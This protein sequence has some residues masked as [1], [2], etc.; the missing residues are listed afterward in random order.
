MNALSPF[1]RSA[2][3]IAAAAVLGMGAL[4]WPYTVDDAFVLAR[5]A[6]RLG[7]GH[8]WT[9]VDGPATDGV[10][11]PLGVVPGALAALGGLDAVLAAKVAGLLGAALAAGLAVRRARKRAIGPLAAYAACGF[12]AASSTLGVWGSA[13]LET[14]LA[15][16][17]ATGLGLAVTAR[18]PRIGWAI[19]S[20]AALPALRPELVPF[21]AVLV[22]GLLRRDR[23]AGL[24]VGLALALALAAVALG[25]GLAFGSPLPMALAAKPP[26]IANGAT[27]V[28][29]ALAFCAG[30]FALVPAALGAQ[31]SGR[32]R[33]VGGAL[34]THVGSVLV[35]GGDWMP[36]YR[37]LC[38][39]LPLYAWMV[40]VGVAEL[41]RDRRAGPRIAV[42]VATLACV[43]PALDLVAQV[44]PLRAAGASREIEGRALAAYLDAHA[45]RVALV[46]VGF[47]S[48]V[49][50]F[51]PID[52]G[53]ITDPAIAR[54]SAAHV[55]APVTLAMLR[56]R[57]ADA[58]VLSSRSEPSVDAHGD[59][60]AL[61]GHPTER[62]L[63]ADPDVRA[64]F[65]VAHVVR[66][67]AST[68]YVVLLPRAP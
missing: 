7:T 62:R 21:A 11:G 24:R 43:L 5:Y 44:G 23:G 2:P 12:V 9:F 35:A 41:A 42:A 14:G 17:A 8:G 58:I 60:T 66:Y 22:L 4:A 61:G 36:G 59:L 25:R 20:A 15:T 10:T 13:G 16:L 33:W 47:L 19:V 63:A 54:I 37:L 46:D 6:T 39:V 52:L 28:V 18:P 29:S 31:R 49:G 26:V 65:S 27:Y 68:W 32:V 57:G 67:S 55:D 51:E 30:G 38:P 53:G 48:W 3:W 64:A 1:S 45:S 34:L 56:A 40:G 50:H